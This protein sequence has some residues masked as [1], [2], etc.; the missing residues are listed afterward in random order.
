MLKNIEAGGE[1]PVRSTRI[2]HLS[3]GRTRADLLSGAGQH[4]VGMYDNVLPDPSRCC[5][6]I[7][8]NLSLRDAEK[9]PSLSDLEGETFPILPNCTDLDALRG[10]ERR[11]NARSPGIDRCTRRERSGLPINYQERPSRPRGGITTPRPA[12]TQSPRPTVGPTPMLS[13]D[14]DPRTWTPRR[15]SLNRDPGYRSR[16]SIG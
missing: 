6:S 10:R 16:T 2:Y 14:V 4:P 13:G 3:P 12:G 15:S 8:L 1:A 5:V 11:F 9:C 7:C